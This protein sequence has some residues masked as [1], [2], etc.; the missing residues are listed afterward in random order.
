[1]NGQTGQAHGER[2]WSIGK[3]ALAAL[4]AIAIAVALA[5]IAG[6]SG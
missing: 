3:I 5:F 1:V 6:Q 4:G 2:P